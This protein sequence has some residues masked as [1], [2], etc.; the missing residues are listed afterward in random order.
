EAG[1][2]VRLQFAVEGLIEEGGR[3]VGVR[4]R[5]KDG[6]E[7]VERAKIVVGADGRHSFVAKAVKAERYNERNHCTYDYYTFFSGVPRR[8]LELW[9]KG[10]L[11]GAAYDS[12]RGLTFVGCWGPRAWFHDFRADLPTNFMRTIEALSPDY[13]ELLRQGK[14]EERIYGTADQPNAYLKPWG[15]GWALVGDAGFMKDQ[16]TAIGMT[17]AFRDSQLLTD[18]L[19]EG[20]GGK[21]PLDDALADYHRR[22][23]EDSAGYYDFVCGIAQMN[24]FSAQ[25]LE[26]FAAMRGNQRAIDAFLGAFGDVVPAP[27]FFSDANLGAITSGA[28]PAL[29][30]PDVLVNY[31]ARAAAAL[32]CPY[33][34]ASGRPLAVATAGGVT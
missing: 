7:V 28:D 9:I 16:C 15:P 17:H 13:A 3:V 8:G 23:D 18:A 1:A 27:E 24:M 5:T 25:Q 4:G 22:R 11:T 30:R 32:R 19:V 29:P 2:E 6:R 34:K 26:L 12:N 10:R 31:E 14:R 33:P 21:R 20:L